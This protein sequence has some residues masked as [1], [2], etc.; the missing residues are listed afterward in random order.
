[1]YLV[2]F[3]LLL[4]LLV[5]KIYNFDTKKNLLDFSKINV[6]KIKLINLNVGRHLKYSKSY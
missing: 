3:L 1:M 4:L 5:K 6:V 2:C